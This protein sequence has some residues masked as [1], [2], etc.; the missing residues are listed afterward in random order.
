MPH[1]SHNPVAD[2]AVV[3]VAYAPDVKLGYDGFGFLLPHRDTKYRVPVPGTLGV[4][5]DSNAM[6]GQEKNKDVVKLTAMI[7]GSDWKDAFGN[8]TV[9]DLDPEVAYKYALRGMSEFL[10]INDQPTHAMV[11]LQKQ[12]IPQYGVGHEARM[13]ELHH[14]LKE[15]YGHLMSVSGASYMG[16]SV[17]D[18]IKNSRMLVE[19][20]LV[21]G[22]LGSR[23]KVVTGLGQVV[24]G[25][26]TQE[27]QDGARLSKG[28]TEVIWKS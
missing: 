18:V 4:V 21:S 14:T 24:E 25:V 8:T 7:G 3:N 12:C 5:F 23:E 1:L 2:V 22:G 16:V 27:M 10:N 15:Y 20:L 17:P 9:D 19:E 28:N 13:R 11:N 6:P 26:S